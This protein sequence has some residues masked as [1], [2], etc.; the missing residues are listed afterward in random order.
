M[1]RTRNYSTISKR[2][3]EGVA[4]VKPG[5]MNTRTQILTNPQRLNYCG[6]PGNTTP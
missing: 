2:I 4:G 1:T 5:L 3:A 6:M